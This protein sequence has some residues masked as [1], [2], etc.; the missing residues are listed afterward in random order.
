M[1]P[2]EAMRDWHCFCCSPFADD[3]QGYYH[4]V[5]GVHG[6]GAGSTKGRTLMEADDTSAEG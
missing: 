2:S 3:C 6:T 5:P 4:V 1:R